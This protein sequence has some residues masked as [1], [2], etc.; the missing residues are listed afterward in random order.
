MTQ[1]IRSVELS[2]GLYVVATPIGNLRDITLRALDTLASVDV[3]YAED[4]RQTKR[5]LDA[6]AITAS[7]K[8]YHD[9]NGAQMRPRIL[10]EI[11]EGRAVALVSD[12]G[13]P[14]ISDPGFKL[15]RELTDADHS[16]YPLPGPSAAIAALSAAGLPTDVFT[17]AGFLPPKSGQRQD[18]LRAFSAQKA[19]LVLYETGPRLVDTLQDLVESCGGDI[20]VVLARELTKLFEEFRR[21]S[22]EDLLAALKDEPPPKG[23]IVLLISMTG[24]PAGEASQEQIDAYLRE[25]LPKLG[26]KGAANEAARKYG[27]PK[28][29]LYA[30]AVELQKSEEP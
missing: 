14:L 17:F 7:L 26:A 25:H 28:R 24:E 16:V 15:V 13:T 8:P 4:T 18:R 23:E 19:T 5:L 21:G 22:A 12:A 9:H 1:L 2:P 29:E 3:I 27:K 6:Y 10:K 30:R 11:E 20:E